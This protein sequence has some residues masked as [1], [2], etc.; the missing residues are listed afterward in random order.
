MNEALARN[1]SI[2][3]LVSFAAQ[4]LE[5]MQLVLPCQPSAV[6]ELVKRADDIAAKADQFDALMDETGFSE[7]NDFTVYMDKVKSI[8]DEFIV[9]DIDELVKEMKALKEVMAEFDIADAI[10]LCHELKRL[11]K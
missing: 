1:M 7:A 8:M 4:E 2:S 3:E 6:T 11:K 5:N 9:D 10:D